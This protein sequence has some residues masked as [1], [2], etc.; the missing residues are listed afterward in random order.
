MSH[1]ACPPVVIACPT[2]NSK[3]RCRPALLPS[4]TPPPPLHLL[5][6][7][8]IHNSNSNFYF[9]SPHHNRTSTSSVSSPS[10]FYEHTSAISPSVNMKS[11]ILLVASSFALGAVAQSLSSLP[12]CGVRLVSLPFHQCDHHQPR[13][14]ISELD[15][16]SKNQSCQIH[17]DKRN[18]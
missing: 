4:S 18:P 5:P 3:A 9:I 7:I 1:L 12:P 11:T 10:S 13:Y 6:P 14:S 17:F 8:H 15:A 2:A 16:R